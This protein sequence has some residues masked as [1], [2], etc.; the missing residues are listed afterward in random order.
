VREEMRDLMR[1]LKKLLAERG[2]RVRI[3][4]LRAR[5]AILT[6]LHATHQI[7]ALTL[8]PDGRLKVRFPAFEAT[9]FLSATAGLQ[10]VAAAIAIRSPLGNRLAWDPILNTSAQL[11]IYGDGR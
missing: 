8:L 1:D 5:F 4:A 10:A 2:C 6:D 3:F 9:T 7:A 11:D